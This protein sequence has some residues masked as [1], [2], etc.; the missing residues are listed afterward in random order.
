[1]CHACTVCSV[2]TSSKIRDRSVCDDISVFPY[3]YICT[4]IHYKPQN[5]INGIISELVI[6]VR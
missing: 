5:D 6:H 3:M 1:M 4:A 2:L